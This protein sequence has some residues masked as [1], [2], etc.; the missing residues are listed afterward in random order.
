MR[1]SSGV[2]QSAV[3]AGPGPSYRAQGDRLC[4]HLTT[5]APFSPPVTRKRPS[6]VTTSA[7][8]RSVVCAHASAGAWPSAL[9]PCDDRVSWSEQ[10]TSTRAVIASTRDTHD[11]VPLVPVPCID[12]APPSPLPAPAPA[13]AVNDADTAVAVAIA[14]PPPPSRTI[15]AVAT[16]PPPPPSQIVAAVA[17]APQPT[18]T[19]TGTTVDTTI[20]GEVRSSNGGPGSGA[21][22]RLT[23]IY[24]SP[25][26]AFRGYRAG[27]DELIQSD[28]S[29]FN[30]SVR[31]RAGAGAGGRSATSVEVG[32]ESTSTGIY[33]L[34]I[35]PH[36]AL[37]PFDLR[38]LCHDPKCPW[39]SRDDYTLRETD[40]AWVRQNLDPRLPDN[41]RRARAGHPECT[42]LQDVEAVYARTEP[43][44][45]AGAAKRQRFFASECPPREIEVPRYESPSMPRLEG[46]GIGCVGAGGASSAGGP[47]SSG[48]GD[49]WGGGDDVA[50]EVAATGF[51]YFNQ[52]RR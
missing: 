40:R 17:T 14:P 46:L 39:L 51:R 37:C 26:L 5:T 12:D 4:V 27:S 9:M 42:S 38:G 25:L 1:H 15:A 3:M 21:G 52:K 13:Q 11:G 10:Y 50:D 23:A 48:S 16:A 19:D 8:S 30:A 49:V 35:D 2:T 6:R 32:V 24:E 22:S 41:M 34:R 28:V 33:A 20:D 43:S 31:T 36:R 44:R 29:L 7:C 18:D 47:G 45:D